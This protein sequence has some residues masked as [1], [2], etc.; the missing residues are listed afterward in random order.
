M[1]LA[2]FILDHREPILKAWD[3]FAATLQLER[4]VMG[5][6]ELRDHAG[7]MLVEIAAGMN[8]AQPIRHGAANSCGKGP[9]AD[10]HTASQMHAE[11]RLQSGFDINQL[12]AEYRA[13]RASVLLLW[14]QQPDG[15][16][17]FREQDTLRFNEAID[18][19][20]A[21]SVARYSSMVNQSQDIFLGVLG[22]DLRSPLGAILLSAEYFRDAGAPDSRRHAKVATGLYATVGRAQKIV[23][24][25][26]DFSRTRVGSGMTLHR[27]DIDL[28]A[29]C[30]SIVEEVRV[31]HPDRTL[32][33]QHDESIVG[34]FD[35]SRMGQVFSNLIENAIKHGSATSP[36]IISQQRQG[37]HVLIAI[38]NKGEPIAAEDAAGIFSPMA[39]R[40]QF[41]LGERGAAAGLGLGLFIARE[42][43]IAHGGTIEATSSA[44]DG[45]TFRVRLPLSDGA[46]A[47]D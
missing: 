27:V 28:T 17:Q 20:L 3:Q 45:T 26:L 18:Q 15:D 32:V 14:S 10:I 41:A 39:R 7:E 8:A 22:H 13:L 16:T 37:D 35:V 47:A 30:E 4:R 36:V 43:I 19:G 29:T 21:E 42:I 44:A 23:E 11:T 34:K 5:D 33:F 1:R 38:H 6:K 9:K 24:N 46:P 12:V 40:S 25:L 2:Q 31:L